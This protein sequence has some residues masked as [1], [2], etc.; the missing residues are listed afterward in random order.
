MIG[1]PSVS[2]CHFKDAKGT[3]ETSR[4]MISVRL[5]PQLF[6]FAFEFKV[7]NGGKV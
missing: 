6:A 7:H 3:H 5:V 2:F 4:G 1:T